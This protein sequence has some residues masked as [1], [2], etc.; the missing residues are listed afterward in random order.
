MTDYLGLPPGAMAKWKYDGSN[1]YLKYIVPICEFLE[2]T[3]N[4][5]F[6]GK[7]ELEEIDGLE[8]IENEVI[9]MF[10]RVDDERRKC[11]RDTLKYFIEVVEDE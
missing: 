7:A 5:L 9:T 1:V 2:T 8:P 3:P 4:Y 10:R 11:I 6:W